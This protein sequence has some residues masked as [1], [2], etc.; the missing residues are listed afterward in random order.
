MKSEKILACLF[1]LTV[2]LLCSMNA[3]ATYESDYRWWGQNQTDYSDS[4]SAMREF[5]CFV[6]AQ[7]RMLYEMGVDQRAEF[8]PDRYL[9]WEIQNGY[10][11]NYMNI[12]QNNCYG[13]AA[14][15]A[16]KGK[17]ITCFP[18]G[19]TTDARIWQS[20]NEGLWTILHVKNW[21]GGDHFILIDNATSKA[22]GTLYFYESHPSITYKESLPLSKY[23]ERISGHIYRFNPITAVIDRGQDGVYTVGES[24][25]ISVRDTPFSWHDLKIY[26]T[27]PGGSHYLYKEVRANAYTMA[28]TEPGYYSCVFWGE[29]TQQGGWVGWKVIDGSA[30]Y[31]LDVNGLL[32]GSFSG[33]TQGWA[34]FDVYINDRRVA[35]DVSDYCEKLRVNTPYEIRNI[36]PVDGKSYAGIYAG[37]RKGRVGS[38]GS[39]VTLSFTTIPNSPG[40]TPTRGIWGGHTYYYYPN[41]CTW[42]EAKKFSEN[43]GGHLVTIESAGEDAFVFD[44]TGKS[45]AWLG[46]YLPEE[47]GSWTWVTGKPASYTNWYPG[48]PDQCES[49]TEGLER[50]VAYTAVKNGQWND[51]NSF[52]SNGFVCEVEPE[53]TATFAP[54]GGSGTMPVMKAKEGGSITLPDCTFTPPV[55]MRF[56][57]WRIGYREYA[58]NT[59]YTMVGDVTINAIWE[60]IPIEP[61]FILPNN[62]TEIGEEAFVECA[63]T[64]VS[65]PEHIR[66]VGSRAFAD[67]A[68]LKHIFIPENIEFIAANAFD[69][70]P[71]GLV[72]HSVSGKYGEYYASR[73][74]FTFKA[75]PHD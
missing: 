3:L 4:Q 47:G 67:C 11:N 36:T 70:V 62:I 17:S 48:Q 45:V 12:G 69:G 33:N 20:I 34:T 35:N 53:Y 14:Y 64:C 5:G 73:Y 39:A 44:L 55:G 51:D 75:I 58:A 43:L 27:A 60:D 32:D 1:I 15:A 72:I 13:P 23:G 31:T 40:G 30:E 57:T 26:R 42:Y 9:D 25:K 63:F 19:E 6:V 59:G 29:G 16:E 68:G 65:L 22:T 61:D 38:G 18:N 54:N 8:N 24:V 52:R 66:I 37:A 2:V 56:R 49:N 71:E 74:G 50:F 28:C 41:G 21:D 7:A 10:V 46:L